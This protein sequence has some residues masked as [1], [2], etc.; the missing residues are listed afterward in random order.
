MSARPPYRVVS[1]QCREGNPGLFMRA[2]LRFDTG[3]K[4]I[5]FVAHRT[6]RA[7]RA[8]SSG[9]PLVVGRIGDWSITVG[10]SHDAAQCEAACYL[11]HN[12]IELIA[13]LIAAV[14]KETKACPGA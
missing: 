7:S 3:V 4:I 10:R 2:V 14:E 12:A 6:L 13:T 8:P 9:T 1:V 11:H 5:A